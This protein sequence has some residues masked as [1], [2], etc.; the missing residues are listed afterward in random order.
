MSTEQETER[1][2][3]PPLGWTIPRWLEPFNRTELA[4]LAERQDMRCREL[5][6]IITRLREELRRAEQEPTK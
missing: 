5:R 1:A 4:Y 6:N 3:I 2:Q